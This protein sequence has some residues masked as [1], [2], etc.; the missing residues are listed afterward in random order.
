MG[1]YITSHLAE[2]LKREALDVPFVS[3][4]IR[5]IEGL[6]ELYMTLAQTVVGEEFQRLY[7]LFIDDIEYAFYRR[8][9]R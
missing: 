4:E 2:R 1:M 5:R 6:G 9:N 3:G 7:T 8:L